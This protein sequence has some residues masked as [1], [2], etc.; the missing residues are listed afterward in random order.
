MIES[1]VKTKQP[2]TQLEVKT[3][4]NLIQHFVGFVYHS[5]RLRC[6]SA[7]Q[8]SSILSAPSKAWVYIDEHERS[9]N[10]GWFAVDMI[11]DRGL[12]DAPATRHNN[13]FFVLR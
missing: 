1:G 3:L 6:S 8:K 5:I 2:T 9:I 7:R 12:L 4:L 11:G 13:A 10:D